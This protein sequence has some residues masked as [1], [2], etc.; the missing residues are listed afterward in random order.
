MY[1]DRQIQQAF[2]TYCERTDSVRDV[3]KLGPLNRQGI[4]K[5]VH[6]GERF[7]VVERVQQQEM[8]GMLVGNYGD[9]IRICQELILKHNPHLPDDEDLVHVY[10]GTPLEVETKPF[11]MVAYHDRVWDYVLEHSK[12]ERELS[13]ARFMRTKND[14]SF[15]LA[16][17]ADVNA[18][19]PWRAI[20]G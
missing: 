18:V 6:A 16:R 1:T 10:A 5:I 3:L 9:E 19:F 8:G 14:I 7:L 13:K 11:F 12:T 2:D 20:L 4:H 15:I 17:E